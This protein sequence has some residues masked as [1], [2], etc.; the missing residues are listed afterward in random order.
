MQEIERKKQLSNQKKEIIINQVYECIRDAASTENIRAI[1]DSE[2][3]TSIEQKRMVK[4]LVK[5][6][7]SKNEIIYEIQRVFGN[8]VLILTK[9]LD[10]E[11]NMFEKIL[12]FAVTGFSLGL[13]FM[14]YKTRSLRNLQ[15]VAAAN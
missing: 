9:N 4:I 12:P 8:D 14:N 6:G 11:R 1:Q 13:L 2:G 15:Q 10:D 3:P 5:Q 7:W